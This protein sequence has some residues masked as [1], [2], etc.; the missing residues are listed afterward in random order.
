MFR[1]SM[2]VAAVEEVTEVVAHPVVVEDTGAGLREEEVEATVHTKPRCG[3]TQDMV[4]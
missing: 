2:A 3:I 4:E 1:D